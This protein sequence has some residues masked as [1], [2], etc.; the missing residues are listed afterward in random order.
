MESVS[1]PVSMIGRLAFLGLFMTIGGA[2]R[3]LKASLRITDQSGR[4]PTENISKQ[5]AECYG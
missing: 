1:F 2:S 4:R 3:G 5:H